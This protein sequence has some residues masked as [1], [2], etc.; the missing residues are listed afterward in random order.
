L[1]A[2]VRTDPA[3][4]IQ[5]G[6]AFRG[7]HFSLMS[8]VMSLSATYGVT[9]RWDV[10]VLVPLVWTD[11]RLD[12]VSA[13]QIVAG[14][15]EAHL[16]APAHFRG[17]AFGIGDVVLRTKYRFLDAPVKFASLIAV[18][19]PSGDPGNFRGIG[20]T[21]VTPSV[22]VSR[23]IRGHDV[24][25]SAGVEMN[26]DDLQRTRAR[27]AAGVTLQPWTRLA[28]LLDLIGSSSFVDDEFRIPRP[29][30]RSDQL[31]GNPDVIE[32]VSPTTVTARVPRSDVL[33]FAV[34]LKASFFGTGAAFVGAIFPVTSD[35]LRADVVPAAGV[36]AS[37]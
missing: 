1:T 20:D 11:L 13:A 3:T 30:H 5:A 36:E 15:T 32:S 18:R 31:F 33:D 21:T 19:V 22:V 14:G 26:A 28:C 25:A 23:A 29:L 16:V 8:H 7:T 4:G 27:Y 35:G 34:G 2:G 6:G 12:G 37:F 9:D 10:N 17:D 24:H